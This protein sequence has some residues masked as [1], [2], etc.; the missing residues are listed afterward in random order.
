MKDGI[1]WFHSGSTGQRHDFFGRTQDEE[2]MWNYKQPEAWSS[3]A[4]V[5]APSEN[6]Q[7]TR[8]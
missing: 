7:F 1:V 4:W 6:S 2:S 3:C 5:A 8:S